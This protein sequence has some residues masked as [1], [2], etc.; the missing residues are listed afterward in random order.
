M[1]IG[2][3]MRCLALAE[4]LRDQVDA[5]ILFA[6]REL[7]GNVNKQ[8]EALGYALIL[9]E[10]MQMKELS[11]HLKTEKPDWLII[12]HYEIDKKQE[13]A[14]KENLPI[15]LLVLDDRI[16]EHQADVLLNHN[17]C[18][19]PFNYLGKVNPDCKVLAGPE[20][21]LIRKEFKQTPIPSR[22][23]PD[24]KV[25]VFM[26]IGGTD[27]HNTLPQLLHQLETF[28]EL[29]VHI[30][31]TRSNPHL[32]RLQ[33]ASDQCPDWH[34]HI[35]HPNLAELMAEAQIGIV[36]PSVISAEC[37]FM[38]LPLIAVKVVDN[39][40]N[41]FNYLRENNFLTL[42]RTDIPDFS[43]IFAPILDRQAYDRYYQKVKKEKQKLSSKLIEIAHV[44]KSP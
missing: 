6:C 22:Q 38:E 13:K 18:A 32:T 14:L 11:L 2:H 1:G 42:E 35:N 9:L 5:R 25:K 28:S 20:Y 31:T 43:A 44:I 7:Y 39:Q 26:A 3:A 21:T 24:E 33:V 4:L 40:S 23:L 29:E 8:I 10:S 34:L 30:A 12:D 41:T 37:I 15:R 17:I 19:S 27:P 36:S 16:K